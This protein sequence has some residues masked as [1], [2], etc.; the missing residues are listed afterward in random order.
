MHD[1][2]FESQEID[3][4]ALVMQARNV[5]VDEKKFTECLRSGRMASLVK[6]DLAAGQQAGVSGTPA[7]FINGL[8]LSGARP[9]EDFRKLIDAELARLGAD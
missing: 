5:G 4:D 9:E 8:Q 7:F 3:D 1:S 2:L 6:R